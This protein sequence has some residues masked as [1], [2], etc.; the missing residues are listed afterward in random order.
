[1]HSKVA[2]VPCGSYEPER[3]YQALR[4]G[5]DLVGGIGKYI[6]TDEK[7][8]LKLNLVREADADR[9]VTT[10]PAVAEMLARILSEEHY[11]DVSAG[12]SGG[13]GSSIK[14]MEHLGM[15]EELTRYGC[16]MA[17]F[18]EAVRTAYPQG[19]HAKEFM[20]AR[21]VV[22]ADA[23]I[24]VCK[25]K[26]HALEHITGAVKNQYGCVQGKHKA[27]GHTRYPSAESMARMIV[28]LNLLVRPCLYIMDGIVAMEGNG[29]TSGDPVPMNVLLFS[30]D[31]VALDSVFARLVYLD[32]ES[33]PTEAAGAQ[34]GLGTWKEEE[35]DLVTPDGP[36]SMRDAVAK[37]GRPGFRVN[38]KKGKAEGIM[39]TIT[40]LR[41]LKPAP[42]IDADKCRK[43]GVCV[44]SCPVDGKALSFS[45][46]RDHP[47]VYN[48]RKCIRC[49]CC[50]EMCPH[51]AIYVRSRS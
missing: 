51:K 44:E 22:E 7:V 3:V 10:H 33:V 17:A 39:N 15:R 8:L 30:T 29:P 27:A 28:D 35:I 43:C 12:D 42:R 48:Y 5:L 38:R 41:F 20:L 1:M 24:S 23:V 19:I 50:Q 4:Q 18:D 25:M 2:L 13:F 14:S 32:P 37:Y 36:L 34:M 40:I 47:P 26:T 45:K 16:R 6:R 49:F 46:G 11:S 31:P 21:D 9:A